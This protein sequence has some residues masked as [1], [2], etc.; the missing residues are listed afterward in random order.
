[1]VCPATSANANGVPAQCAETEALD[2]EGLAKHLVDAHGLLIDVGKFV[3]EQD[4]TD[5][6]VN[7]KQKRS[8]LGD[9]DVNQTQ[10][11]GGRQRG[12]DGY[13]LKKL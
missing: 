11:G 2:K 3:K 8:A 9:K 1:M 6:P 5:Q 4:S 12:N 7:K 13:D 10:R